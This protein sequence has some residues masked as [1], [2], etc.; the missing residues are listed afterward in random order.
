MMRSPWRC[1]VPPS[2]FPQATRKTSDPGISRAPRLLLDPSDRAR[3]R[4][5]ARS[6]PWPPLGSLDRRLGPSFSS[7][8]S[9][10]AR[11]GRGPPTP[12]RSMSTSS[13]RSIRADCSTWTPMIARP[14]CSGDS[15]VAQHL[16]PHGAAGA[17]LQADLVARLA[18]ADEPSQIVRRLDGLSVHLDDHVRRLELARC[19]GVR[20]DR[21]HERA[22]GVG[23]DLE[24]QL[25]QSDGCGDL[26]RAIHLAQVLAASLLEVRA[27]RHDRLRRDELGA[28]G[29]ERGHQL[30]EQRRLAQD[31][32]DEVDP[33]RVIVRLRSLDRH[34]V[35]ER[36]GAVRQDQV[37]ARREEPR[38]RESGHEQQEP[39]LDEPTR[40]QKRPRVRPPSTAIVAPVTYAARSE[41]RKQTTSPSSRGAPMRRRGIVARSDSVGPSG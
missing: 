3:R 35:R 14:S 9:E 8:S 40:S 16:R 12:P 10:N 25:A 23:A 11:P 21:D 33:A 13:G 19:R 30:L 32:V 2:R 37:A 6:R 17:D 27:G 29:P 7:T 15:T 5:R 41:A 28:V 38:D 18:A 1:A 36:L 24:P 22:R 20:G 26:L 4:R 34:L 31:H 39:G